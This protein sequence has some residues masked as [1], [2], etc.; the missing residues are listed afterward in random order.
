MSISPTNQDLSDDNTFSQIKFRVP[1][2][3]KGHLVEQYI[4][5]CLD[6]IVFCVNSC[7]CN[8]I[9]QTMYLYRKLRWYIW[10]ISYYAKVGTYPPSPPWFFKIIARYWGPQHDVICMRGSGESALKKCPIQVV[11]INSL[12]NSGKLFLKLNNSAKNLTKSNL[13]KSS[14]N[15]T[16]KNTGSLRAKILW[17][18]SFKLT[19]ITNTIKFC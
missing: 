16:K 9:L 7:P 17:D 10:F 5:Y 19:I 1:V 15:G 2:P 13:N 14:S 12:V 18:G 4:L 11:I 3:L 8:M 6:N